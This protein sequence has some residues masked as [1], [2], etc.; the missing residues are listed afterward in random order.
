MLVATKIGARGRLFIIDSSIF[1]GLPANFLPLHCINHVY[2]L[3]SKFE[4]L[5][6]EQKLQPLSKAIRYEGIENVPRRSCCL[7]LFV[8]YYCGIDFEKKEC[9]QKY[10]YLRE[11]IVFFDGESPHI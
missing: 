9:A 2:L 3:F 6:R 1:V 4:V 11:L 5:L 10:N 8:S 7:C